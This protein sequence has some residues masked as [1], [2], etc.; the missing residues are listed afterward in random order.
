VL[1][2]GRLL[3]A[4]AA[5]LPRQPAELADDGTALTLACGSTRYRLHLLPLDGYPVL[6]ELPGPAGHADPAE[7]AAAVRQMTSPPPATT[8]CRPS[9]PPRSPSPPT[10]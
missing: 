3:A 1:A 2:S 7:F 10:R 6:P 5:V 4:I 8:P 9:A